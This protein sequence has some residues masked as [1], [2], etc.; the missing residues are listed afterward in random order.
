VLVDP[1]DFAKKG[2]ETHGF[3]L[4]EII[5][6]PYR[7]MMRTMPT[8]E[9]EF[10]VRVMR[11][12]ARLKCDTGCNKT[13]LTVYIFQAWASRPK[14]GDPNG[15][16]DRAAFWV[17]CVTT[18]RSNTPR[19]DKICSQDNE[20]SRRL[21][22]HV[23]DM[24]SSSS[25]VS[26]SSAA[27]KSSS[28]DTEDTD[29][30][31]GFPNRNFRCYFNACL[32][33]LSHIVPLRTFFSELTSLEK[34]PESVRAYARFQQCLSGPE[35]S[36]LHKCLRDLDNL[37][38][39]DYPPGLQHDMP[40][41]LHALLTLLETGIGI[42]NENIITKSFYAQVHDRRVCE[43]G[44]STETDMKVLIHPVALSSHKIDL[45]ELMR[46]APEKMEGSNQWECPI[47]EK[48]V[49]ATKQTHWLEYPD[50]LIIQLTRFRFVGDQLVKLRARV[51]FGLTLQLGENVSGLQDAQPVDY[52]LTAITSHIGEWA[53]SGHYVA[54]VTQNGKWYYCD[55]TTVHHVEA[56][57]VL[58]AEAYILFYERG[59]Q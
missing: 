44:H 45:P 24:H 18:A 19:A 50:V 57:D 33:C 49:N 13:E 47:C 2:S 58:Q 42:T 39:V 36:N 1:W 40:E 46:S 16:Y 37:F 30:P 27:P 17:Q 56:R 5:P 3:D 43:R 41:V 9:V 28:V 51:D 59:H 29:S 7:D 55:D 8:N 14:K 12:V 35:G 53:T 20:H 54:Y 11:D 31:I 32:Q 38:T 34:F 4:Y 48:L 25:K 6:T 22:Q 52:H 23:G 10:L 21:G 26:R 15:V